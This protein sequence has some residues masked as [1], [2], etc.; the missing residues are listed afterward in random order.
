MCQVSFDC[1]ICAKSLHLTV[2]YVP[3]F[4]LTVLYVPSM[5]PV[6]RVRGIGGAVDKTNGKVSERRGNLRTFT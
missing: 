5:F 2:L 1:F 4:F 6:S 3:S